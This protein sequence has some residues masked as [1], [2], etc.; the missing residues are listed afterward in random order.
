MK[1]KV[2]A[3]AA[4]LPVLLVTAVALVLLVGACSKDPLSS[5]YSRQAPAV[6]DLVGVY[7]P[8]SASITTLLAQS[9]SRAAPVINL[10]PDHQISIAGLNGLG[11]KEFDGNTVQ[12]DGLQGAWSLGRNDD[13]WVILAETVE[14]LIVRDQ[15]PYGLEV[16]VGQPGRERILRFERQSPMKR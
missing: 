16:R 10:L 15:P 5:A 14:I 8:D 4:A 7:V 1:N 2:K 9:G 3:S 6:T 13:H 11:L 12:G